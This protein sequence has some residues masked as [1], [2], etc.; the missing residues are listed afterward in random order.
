MH[1]N[2]A[3]Q[4]ELAELKER[5]QQALSLLAQKDIEISSKN[6]LLEESKAKLTTAEQEVVTLRD[7]SF[8]FFSTNQAILEQCQKFAALQG[9]KGESTSTN[10]P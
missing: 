1:D 9:N 7:Q 6:A 4:A 10:R 3:I 2:A 8:L 5:Y